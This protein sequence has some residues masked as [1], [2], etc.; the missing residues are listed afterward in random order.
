MRFGLAKQDEY[1]ALASQVKALCSQADSSRRLAENYQKDSDTYRK[2]MDKLLADQVPASQKEFA[3]FD[4]PEECARDFAEKAM[5]MTDQTNKE[6]SAVMT[7]VQVPVFENGQWTTKPKYKYGEISAREHNNVVLNALAGLGAKTEGQKYLLHTHPNSI[8]TNYDNKGKTYV[9]QPDYF[10]GAPNDLFNTGD[11]SIPSLLGIKSVF[12][13][14]KFLGQPLSGY[15]G[16]YLVSPTGKLF[17][18]EGFGQGQYY[19]NNDQEL[20]NT[21]NLKV[22]D[23]FP[24]SKVQWDTTTNTYKLGYWDANGNFIT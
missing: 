12:D 10:S 17:F 19:A 15:N 24:Q 7:T 4:S 1:D 3:L 8:Y 13:K 2:G 11:A 5:P 9:D 16:I 20:K 6:Y 21:G 22:I 23:N 18:Y 14:A